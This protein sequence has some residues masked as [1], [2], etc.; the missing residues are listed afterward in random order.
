MVKLAKAHVEENPGSSRALREFA[1]IRPKDAEQGVHEVLRKHG[2]STPI[3][4]FYLNLGPGHMARF[5]FLKFSDWVR[6]LLDT[7]RLR[8]LCGVA[9]WNRTKEILSQFW[10]RYQDLH[11]THTVFQHFDRH[12]LCQVVPFFSHSDE[13]R[14]YKH[15][16]LFVLSSHGALGRGTKKFIA[17][18]K[19][20][21]RPSRNSMGLNF[22]GH[23][24]S[25]QFAS[26][27]LLKSIANQH[28]HALDLIMKE[29]ATDVASLAKDGITSTDGTKHIWCI[30]IGTKGDLPALV[31]LGKLQRSF[32]HG[33]KARSSK[34]PCKGI[35]HYCLAGKEGLNNTSPYPYEDMSLVPAWSTT[36][37]RE[38]PWD[39]LSPP[40]ILEGAMLR[41]E[42]PSAFFLTD[43][44]HNFHL[45][46]AKVWIGGSIIS[47]LERMSHF[48]EGRSVE[49]KLA[50]LTEEYKTF[51]RHRRIAPHLLELSRE[52]LS[53]PTGPTCPQG[54][55][56]KGA[57]STHLMMF[58]ENFCARYIE[59]QT[60]DVVLKAIVA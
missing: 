39:P 46:V 11:P 9:D 29:Y 40:A 25:T 42:A 24:W 35:C 33:P 4:P 48:P 7:N 27:T 2:L 3:Q 10:E 50:W 51:M 13:G 56:S 58:L 14:S 43:I 45:G 26:A 28:P 38:L 20:K 23:T 44:W 32:S 16:A 60:D 6:Y 47:I 1:A 5:P 19:H 49:S 22:V 54:R 41:E 55:W 57:V 15:Q 34:D 59:N 36:L 31:K 12:Q 8:Q 21:A 18:N 30:H 52:T 37:H 53:W 17:E